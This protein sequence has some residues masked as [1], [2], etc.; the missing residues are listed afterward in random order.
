M[1]YGDE[2][3]GMTD[4]GDQDEDDEEQAAEQFPLPAWAAK[5]DPWIQDLTAKRTRGLPWQFTTSDGA[6]RLIVRHPTIPGKLLVY[7]EGRSLPRDES[8]RTSSSSASVYDRSEVSIFGI[9]IFFEVCILL[10]YCTILVAPKETLNRS[11]DNLQHVLCTII[12]LL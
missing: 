5:L 12:F 6:R 1:K 3:Q 11:C 4:Q 2:R 7:H 10:L 8:S 9:Y